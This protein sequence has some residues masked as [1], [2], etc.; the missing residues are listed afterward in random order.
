MIGPRLQLRHD[1]EIGAQEAAAELGDQLFA[2]AFG[3]ILGIAGEIP[4]DPVLWRRPMAIMPI[5]A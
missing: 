5:S 2:G 4:T 3:L 1:T